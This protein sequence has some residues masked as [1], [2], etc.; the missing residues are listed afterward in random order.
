MDRSPIRA[1]R[2]KACNMGDLEKKRDPVAI[3]NLAALKRIIH[4]GVEFKT[5][6]QEI[7][8]WEQ[9]VQVI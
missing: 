1:Q 5:L 9:M 8:L 7:L 6:R 4:P 2:W 3:K